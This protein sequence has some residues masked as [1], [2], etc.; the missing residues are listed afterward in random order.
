M[1]NKYEELIVGF[2]KKLR[3][4]MS[5]YKSLQDENTT[6]KEELN[7]KQN[8]LMEAHSEVLELRK[9]CDNLRMARNLGSSEED[10]T[11]SK[12]RIDK[13]VREIDKCLALLDE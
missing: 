4:L 12:Q 13:L 9:T 3:K 11:N 8:D 7:R 5:A 10:R 6:L 1:T 2:E